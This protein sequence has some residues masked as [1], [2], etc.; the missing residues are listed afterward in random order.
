MSE[1][2]CR[3]C[4]TKFD[5]SATFC[6]SCGAKVEDIEVERTVPIPARAARNAMSHRTKLL[7][8]CAGIVLFLFFLFIFIRHLPGGDNPVIAAQPQIVVS[9]AGKDE[10]IKPVAVT[11]EIQNGKISIALAELKRNRIVEFEYHAPTST[12]PLLALITPEGKI[13]TAIRMCEPCNSTS[14][15]IEGENLACANCETKWSLRNFEGVQGTCQKYAPA[16]IPSKVIGDFVVIDEAV[17]ANWK[18]RI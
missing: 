6:T 18:M 1:S 17:V 5:P 2:F 11:A 12:I 15:R 7:Y 3:K 16:P 9:D 13:V 8:T 10:E 4:G 14:F